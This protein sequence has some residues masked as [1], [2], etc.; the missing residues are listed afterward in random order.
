MMIILYDGRDA[1]PSRDGAF[2]VQQ[3]PLTANAVFRDD[4]TV[5][6]TSVL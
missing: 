5:V 2:V 3:C 6:D 4:R 1:E